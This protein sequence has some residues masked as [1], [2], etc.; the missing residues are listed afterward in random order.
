MI[1]NK[2][3]QI[4]IIWISFQNNKFFTSNRV[5]EFPKMSKLLITIS[6]PITTILYFDEQLIFAIALMP[7]RVF[8]LLPLSILEYV[9]ILYWY[10]AIASYWDS[11]ILRRQ[12]SNFLNSIDLTQMEMLQIRPRLFTQLRT[13]FVSY[14]IEA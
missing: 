11:H 5:P 1:I 9:L 12:F 8:L 13:S 14:L 6:L 2:S 10:S 7:A 4:T 3:S